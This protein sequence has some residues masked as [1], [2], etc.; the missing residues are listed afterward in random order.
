[1]G[2]ISPSHEGLQEIGILIGGTEDQNLHHDIA[3]Q[4]VKWYAEPINGTE[5]AKNLSG[6]E[7]LVG[8]ESDRIQY[9]KMMSSPYAPSTALF[10]LGPTGEML[11]G[12]QKDR[13]LR[14]R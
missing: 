6:K 14:D 10:A 9:N 3:T 1:M 7:V 5:T 2:I 4:F 8:W 13:I 12:V 11:L